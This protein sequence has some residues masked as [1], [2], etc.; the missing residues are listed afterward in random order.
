[1]SSEPPGIVSGAS[2]RFP[3]TSAMGNRTGSSDRQLGPT[4]RIDSQDRRL[5]PDDPADHGMASKIKRSA[6]E[7]SCRT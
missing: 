1:M 2:P 7:I 3:S 6:F 5:E 4:A